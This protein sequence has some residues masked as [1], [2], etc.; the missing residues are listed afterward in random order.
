MPAGLVNAK[1]AMRFLAA[2]LCDVYFL[3]VGTLRDRDLNIQFVR[4]GLKNSVKE[5]V[6][7]LG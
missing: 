6:E 2:A 4:C 5:K 1:C 7:T 3:I